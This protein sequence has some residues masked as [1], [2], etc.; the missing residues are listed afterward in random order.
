MSPVRN[1]ILSL[2]L[3][4]GLQAASVETIVGIGNPASIDG[5]SIRASLN[6]PFGVVRGPDGALWF[7]EYDGHRVRKIDDQGNVVTIVGNGEAGFS[8]D[9]GPALEASLNRPHEIRFDAEGDLYIADMRNHAIRKV[10]LRT[11]RIETIAGDG[12]MGFSGDGGP[13]IKARLRQPH[14][15]QFGPEGKLYIADTGNHRIR[16]IDLETKAISTL[17]GDG[18]RNPTLDGAPYAGVSMNGPRSIDFDARGDLWI[19]LR[20]ANQVFRLDMRAGTIHHIAGT[21]EKGFTGNGGPARLATLSGPKGIA[22]APNGDA[23]LADTESHT[24]RMIEAESGIL[25]LIAGTGEKGDGPD[26]PALKCRFARL[27]GIFLD[28]D[29]SLLVGDSENHRI[30][31]I[32]GLGR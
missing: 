29:G 22:I 9:G 20:N 19:V 5:A 15:I 10:D 6:N 17:S 31:A 25:R 2:L 1:L 23:Y 4:G 12:T 32:R 28:Y 26:G 21:G 27:H 18:E 14:S 24:V 3:V 7:C 11:N 8:G 13:A 16:A 30:R